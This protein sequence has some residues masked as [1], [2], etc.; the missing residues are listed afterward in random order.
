MTTPTESSV[1]FSDRPAGLDENIIWGPSTRTQRHIERIAARLV[2]GLNS[3]A[4]P[5][6][7]ASMTFAVHGKW[8]TGKSS[9]LRM[10]RE[11]A[12]LLAEA[13]GAKDRI[14]FCTYLAP[15]HEGMSFDVRTTLAVRML[16]KLAGGTQQA[17]DKHVRFLAE[18]DRILPPGPPSGSV[19][20]DSQTMT[21]IASAL[22]QLIDF[23]QILTKELEAH[24]GQ[25]SKVMV[26]IIDD[27]D[28]CRT[29]FVWQILDTIQQFSDV[30]DLHFV[31]GVDADHLNE[32]VRGRFPQ[33]GGNPEYA[34]EKYVQDS[35]R[36]PE[37]KTGDQG[38]YALA[39]L[40][41]QQQS[42]LYKTLQ[43]G[44]SLLDVGL[45]IRTPR[46]VK[47]FLNRIGG[48]LER[49][50][51]DT[52][53]EETNLVL[54]EQLL[55]FGWPAFYEMFFLP[56]VANKE[57]EENL[58]FL[59][60]AA[61]QYVAGTY[62]LP[63][64]RFVIQQQAH[65][66]PD[67]DMFTPDL[68]RFLG[69]EPFWFEHGASEHT[70]PERKNAIPRMAAAH[71]ENE[72][73]SMQLQQLFFQLRIAQDPDDLK[74]REILNRAVS[75]IEQKREFL[76][77]EEGS[78]IGNF[79]VLALHARLT[80]V[81]Q[82]LFE[83]SYELDPNHV[84]N[85]HNYIDFLLRAGAD[86]LLQR[87]D[88]LLQKMKNHPNNDQRERTMMLEL[89]MLQRI[90][91]TTAPTSSSEM[92]SEAT[93][94]MVD[95]LIQQFETDPKPKAFSS[96]MLALRDLNDLRRARMV[97]QKYH[98]RVDSDDERYTAI[99]GMA[100]MLAAS[101]KTEDESEA[102]EMYRYL[103]DH[104]DQYGR[105]S[106][107]NLLAS[108]HN[109]ATLLI[110]RGLRQEALRQWRTC[111][112]ERPSDV[113]VRRALAV[114][115]VEDYGLSEV[116]EQVFRGQPVNWDEYAELFSKEKEELPKR[117]ISAETTPWWETR[118]PTGDSLP[119]SEPS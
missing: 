17:I 9:A 18:G 59:Q 44:M 83:L 109:Y 74:Y 15:A 31:I 8:G 117:F 5:S 56:A 115:L 1:Q 60:K 27:L 16:G 104:S 81:S 48:E 10:I 114:L 96:V 55:Q 61:R 21:R 80:D 41:P 24:D 102:L 13:S 95:S 82:W 70:R 106:A 19:G 42:R 65:Q 79:A 99:R 91:G 66:Y 11:R 110:R 62:N 92:T 49:L 86:D 112:E 69:T 7:H 26:V 116:A 101:D 97:T 37:L 35:L 73:L 23:D 78:L 28:R 45:R 94:A 98:D 20:S 57:G 87:A 119:E 36:L 3:T 54:K 103:I 113:A 89:R 72:M 50:G 46:S 22:S 34:L 38:K 52:S 2:A 43:A 88:E 71:Q 111:Y 6:M 25:P 58:R 67:L 33:A 32:T 108:R 84:N 29:D 75:L 76:E 47:R 12:L 53:T 107:Q 90:K 14:H 63:L 40:D 51:T 100:D 85:T 64:L 68:M 4:S 77:K 39:L 30:P 118:E 105:R 93:S